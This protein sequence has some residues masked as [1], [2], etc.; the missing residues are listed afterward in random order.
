MIKVF[1]HWFRWRTLAQM[2]F[3]L[4]FVI[5]GMLIVSMWVGSGLPINH[6]QIIVFA[7]ILGPPEAHAARATCE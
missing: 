5:V 4:S 7:V 6:K 2:I 1:N 3:D